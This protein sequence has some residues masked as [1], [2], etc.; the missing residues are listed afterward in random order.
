MWWMKA[1]RAAVDLLKSRMTVAVKE[2]ISKCESRMLNKQ[3]IEDQIDGFIEFYAA[4]YPVNDDD[5][6]YQ[7]ARK[8]AERFS[9]VGRHYA[10]SHRR[11]ESTMV[12]KSSLDPGREAVIDSKD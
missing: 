7:T 5:S 1:R 8:T 9:P 6:D 3:L 4:W 12:P 2:M 11:A 10:T